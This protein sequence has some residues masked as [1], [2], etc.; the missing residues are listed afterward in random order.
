MT[1]ALVYG[2]VMAF[3]WNIL[4]LLIGCLVNFALGAYALARPINGPRVTFGLMSLAVGVWC[5]C[6]S[7]SFMS[8][9]VQDKI[10]WTSVKYIG[11]TLAPVMWFVLALQL[12]RR[13]HWLTR[14]LRI[15]L[16]T[17]VVAVLTIVATN[18]FHFEFWRHFFIEPGFIEARTVHGALFSLYSIPSY[19]LMLV[20]IYFYLDFYRRTPERFHPRAIMLVLAA[21]IPVAAD[22]FQQGGYKLLPL[23]D[24]VTLSLLV[25]TILFGTVVLR[26]RALEILPIARDLVIQNIAAAVIVL[27]KQRQILEVNPFAFGL[28]KTDQP[29]DKPLE[30]AFPEFAG[31]K[32]AQGMEREIE[33]KTEAGVRWLLFRVSEVRNNESMG[34]VLV[35]LDITG[36][37][38]AE[39]ELERRATTDPLT[40]VN[41]RRAFFELAENEIS[42]AKR[43]GDQLAV[44]MIDIDYFKKINDT[45]GHQAGDEVLVALAERATTTLRE[46]DLIARYGG[47]EF[48]G[49]VSGDQ[50][51]VMQGAERLR[52][53]YADK[54][55][56]TQSGDISITISVGVAFINSLD[57]PLEATIEKADEALYASKT[58]GR[59]R[60]TLHGVND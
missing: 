33:L 12:T 26:Y 17:W 7:I 32:I 21:I 14:G 60:V 23:V 35:G 1:T 37:K 29:L 45:Q 36:R 30:E 8:L 34:M 16:G 9:G 48:I 59:N 40:G 44:M 20:S 54:P 53:A 39:Q 56:A 52:L 25:S 50:D 42:R 38:L 11:S 28:S 18:S 57:E 4:P 47:E 22:A 6:Y 13:G 19:L 5:F 15:A 27:N 24:Q 51:G 3:Y 10:F 58:N 55:I 31:L 41:N 49:L 46:V 2:A 43:A